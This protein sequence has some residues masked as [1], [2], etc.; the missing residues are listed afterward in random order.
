MSAYRPSSYFSAPSYPSYHHPSSYSASTTSY[1][2]SSYSPT[3]SVYDDCCRRAPHR[4]YSRYQSPLLSQHISPSS[5]YV[6]SHTNYHS[7]STHIPSSSSYL[8]PSSSST[9]FSSSTSSPSGYSSPSSH[10]HNSSSMYR[11]YSVA[12]TMSDS[13]LYSS[14]ISYSALNRTSTRQYI[15]KYGKGIHSAAHSLRAQ[16]HSPHSS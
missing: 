1:P 15:N 2:L 11:T 10:V 8:P 3:T 14:P 12:P 6:Q 5:S 16:A 9:Y 13:S 7:P 4:T